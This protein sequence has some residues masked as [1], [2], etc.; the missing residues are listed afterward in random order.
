M[1][2]AV[3]VAEDGPVRHQWK[4]SPLFPVKSPCPSVGKY[5]G[6]Q[7]RCLGAY[8]HKNRKRWDEIDGFWGQGSVIGKGDNM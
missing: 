5:E 7:G 4:K 1:A 6:I 3:L 2:P 8:L